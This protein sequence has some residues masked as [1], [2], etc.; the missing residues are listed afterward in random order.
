MAVEVT[1]NDADTDQRDRVDEPDG[2]AAAGIPVYLLVDRDEC[3]LV[4]HS[5]PQRGRYRMR[6][7]WTYGE[8]VEL[9]T[10]SGSPW[11]QRN[12][13]T[14]RHEARGQRPHRIGRAAWLLSDRASYVTG[15]VLRV[16]GG[17]RA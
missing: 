16:D 2:Y 1:S 13:R 14:T 8:A 3:T 11:I 5:E 4:V 17:S 9:P 15:T 6:R 7:V 10:R 12:S